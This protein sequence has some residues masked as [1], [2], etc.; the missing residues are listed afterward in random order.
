MGGGVAFNGYG[1]CVFNS[2]E[3][4]QQGNPDR[5]AHVAEGILD[6]VQISV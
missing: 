3:V 2:D 1:I 4:L 5:S 6:D